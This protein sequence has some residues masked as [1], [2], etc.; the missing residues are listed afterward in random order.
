[1]PSAWPSVALPPAAA[2]PKRVPDAPGS[3]FPASVERSFVFSP[4]AIP[5]FRA[6]PSIIDVIHCFDCILSNVAKTTLS[7]CSD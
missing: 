6:S 4:E 2:D 7:D 5:P 1:M 3:G